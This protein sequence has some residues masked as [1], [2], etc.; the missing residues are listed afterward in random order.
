[1]CQNIKTTFRES[2]GT[3]R[4]NLVVDDVDNLSPTAILE[5]TPL[6]ESDLAPLTVSLDASRSIDPDGT[7]EQYRWFSSD[8]QIIPAGEQAQHTMAESLWPSSFD[9]LEI[10]APFY[11][12]QLHQ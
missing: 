10:R 1:M 8:G 2:D 9:G 6:D 3:N 12:T 4:T 5:A 7:I 11:T